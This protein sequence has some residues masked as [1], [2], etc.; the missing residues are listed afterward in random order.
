M[1]K[2]I[3]I[4]ALFIAVAIVYERNYHKISLEVE[5]LSAQ[6]Y[7]IAE[8]IKGAQTRKKNLDM[9]IMSQSDPR[10]ITLTLMRVLGVVPEGET[11]LYFKNG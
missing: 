10:W 2:Y 8:L 6:K 11:K 1:K 9:Q 4:V 3:G 5:I 7:E